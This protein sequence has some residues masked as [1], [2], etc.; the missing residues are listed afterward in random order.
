VLIPLIPNSIFYLPCYGKLIIKVF[1]NYKGAKNL[2][3][4]TASQ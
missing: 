2:V 1:N 4:V 3:E